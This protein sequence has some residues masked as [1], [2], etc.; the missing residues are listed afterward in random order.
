MSR[1]ALRRWRRPRGASGASWRV[2]PATWL[3][4][5]PLLLLGLSATA[6]VT[7]AAS[8][9]ATA[10][11]A[12]AN[13]VVAPPPVTLQAA[14]DPEQLGESTTV[15]IGFRIASPPGQ[16]P[17]P[18]TE[19]DV[20]LPAGMGLAATTLGLETCSTEALL[21]GGADGCSVESR[22]GFGSAS[23]E[24][25]LG[26]QLVNE[27]ARVSILMGEPIAGHT[28][29]LYYFEGKAPVIAPLVFPSEVLSVANSPTSEFDTA[30]PPIPALPGSPDVSILSLRASIGPNHLTYYKHVH[31][32]LVG[33]KP[34]G[35]SVP[36]TCP[37]GGFVFSGEFGFQ[38]GSHTTA[39]TKVACPSAV[40]HSRARRVHRPFSVPRRAAGNHQA[41]TLDHQTSAHTPGDARR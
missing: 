22:M 11:A 37:R 32:R 8:T 30:I 2:R 24:A 10:T 1:N 40:A 12:A 16:P 41:S 23:V 19:F 18:L 34:I 26:S 5:A 35:M 39:A 20:R 6:T 33:Y 31:G 28:T 27:S 14:L 13:G 29:M 7:A 4:G 21:R 15:S 3:V 38:D 36:P 9:T 17:S 25:S